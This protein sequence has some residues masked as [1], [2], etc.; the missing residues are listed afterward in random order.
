MNYLLLALVVILVGVVIFLFIK[1]RRAKRMSAGKKLHL[2]EILNLI[3]QAITDPEK[4]RFISPLKFWVALIIIELPLAIIITFIVS[5]IL[6]LTHL[7][8]TGPDGSQ[9]QW[10]VQWGWVVLWPIVYVGMLIHAG[11]KGYII[12]PQNHNR[13]VEVFGKLDHIQTEPGLYFLFPYF[14]WVTTVLGSLADRRIQLFRFVDEGGREEKMKIDLKDASLDMIAEMTIA[15]TDLNKATY[16]QQKN[17]SIKA[18]TRRVEAFLRRSMAKKNFDDLEDVLAGGASLQLAEEYKKEQSGNEY[19]YVESLG[20]E[21]KAIQ[22]NDLILS[23]EQQEMLN[24]VLK[25]RK[26]KE[27]AVY[28]AKAK[29][30]TDSGEAKGKKLLADA[31]RVALEKKAQGTRQTIKELVAEGI[32]PTRAIGHLEEMAKWENQKITHFVGENGKNSVFD[33][34]ALGVGISQSFQAH[35]EKKLKPET[36]KTQQKK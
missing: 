3:I 10:I 27:A 17:D 13:L 6:G 25:A 26:K 18:V 34:A 30:E 15:I 32:D 36:E 14:G 4:K 2:A 1:K 22:L 8:K 16:G 24:S 21:I 12:L 19:K 29:V 33:G 31:D 20:L 35:E 5:E 7:I 28:E 11:V 23:P 9:W